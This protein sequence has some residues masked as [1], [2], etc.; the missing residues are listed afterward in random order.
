MTDEACPGNCDGCIWW[1]EDGPRF[2]GMP[3]DEE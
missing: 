3:R 1:Q 2:C